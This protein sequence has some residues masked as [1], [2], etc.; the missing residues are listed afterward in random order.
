[1]SP[2][3]ELRSQ[4]ISVWADQLLLSR[5]LNPSFHIVVMPASGGKPEFFAADNPNL[6][7]IA[8]DVSAFADT[9]I[10]DVDQ[11]IKPN[12]Y[13]VEAIPVYKHSLSIIAFLVSKVYASLQESALARNVLGLILEHMLRSLHDAINTLYAVIASNASPVAGCFRP[14]A[15]KR[16]CRAIILHHR[17]SKSLQA[18]DFQGPLR[19]LLFP[20]QQGVMSDLFSLAHPGGSCK[21]GELLAGHALSFDQWVQQNCPELPRV[22]SAKIGL[23]SSPHDIE[24]SK[25]RRG[26][27]VFDEQ[28]IEVALLLGKDPGHATV[29][30]VLGDIAGGTAS[31]SRSSTGFTLGTTNDPLLG[32]G[33]GMKTPTWEDATDRTIDDKSVDMS[34]SETALTTSADISTIVSA[35]MGDTLEHEL[36]MASQRLDNDSSTSKAESGEQKIPPDSEFRIVPKRKKRSTGSCSISPDRKRQQYEPVFD[37]PF[38]PLYD[39]P[40]SM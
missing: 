12:E 2:L 40:S 30:D 7:D 38:T 34:E 10:S 14:A 36:E 9:L 4:S 21:H 28:P 16:I 33:N 17:I 1:M 20:F 22:S 24:T 35:E 27:T 11:M 13:P 25:A 32:I 18:L 5:F 31:S 19:D 37:N 8:F 26:S 39:E 6:S 29:P 3:S 23:G 15:S